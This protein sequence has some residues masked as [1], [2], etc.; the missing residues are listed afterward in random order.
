MNGGLVSDGPDRHEHT[1]PPDT[2][3]RD[4][5]VAVCP[6]CGRTFVLDRIPWERTWR[7][8]WPWPLDRAARRRLRAAAASR[9]PGPARP[10]MGHMRW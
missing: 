4:G 5:A 6:G 1:L 3:L 10:G 7:R 2:G 8:M 9:L